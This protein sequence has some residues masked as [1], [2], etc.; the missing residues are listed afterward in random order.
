MS[1]N[2]HGLPNEI[3]SKIF[4]L[5]DEQSLGRAAQVNKKWRVLS[6]QDCVW[7]GRFPSME[8]LKGDG[9]LKE[10]FN[11]HHPIWT[12]GQLKW[13]VKNAIETCA[14][15]RA[16]SMTVKILSVYDSNCTFVL[17]MHNA[18]FFSIFKTPVCM[19]KVY[20]LPNHIMNSNSGI[21]QKITDIAPRSQ[22]PKISY[23]L[24]ISNNSVTREQEMSC[25]IEHSRCLDFITGSFTS[26]I[27]K[28]IQLRSPSP[29]DLLIKIDAVQNDA[30]DAQPRHNHL[31]NKQLLAAVAFIIL[32]T[33]VAV[34]INTNSEPRP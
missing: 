23:E 32:A 28:S 2:I 27:D 31:L 21:T 20:F 7:Q 5:L 19:H 8:H 10:L 17:K 11:K 15:G 1:I 30:L 16:R 26:V 12:L 25:E 6:S 24:K 22:S 13:H 3:N 29:Q 34:L 9:T 14:T 4:T 18:S 33:G